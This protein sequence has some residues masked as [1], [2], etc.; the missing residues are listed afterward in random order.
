MASITVSSDP[1]SKGE[2]ATPSDERQS[3]LQ[4]LERFARAGDQRAFEQLVR[5]HEQL[6]LGVC[7]RQLR[8]QQDAEDAF[9][10]TFLVLAAKAGNLGWRASIS[11]WL[12]G[13]ALRV[14]RKAHQRRRRR[15][16]R[17]V[18]DMELLADNTLQRVA[19]QH[20]AEI[21][22]EELSRLPAKYR[23]PLV[24]FYLQGKSR[25]EAADELGLTESVVKGR[26]ERG[27]NRL[28]TRLMIRGVSLSLALAAVAA[29]QSSAAAAMVPGG[30][31]LG[32]GSLVATTVAAAAS[33]S[34]AQTGVSVSS[35][36]LSLVNG[37]FMMT[38][39]MILR[40]A[41]VTVSLALLAVC[42]LLPGEGAASSLS[43]AP[44]PIVLPQ[45]VGSGEARSTGSEVFFTATGETPTEKEVLGRLAGTWE[46]ESAMDGGRV[47]KLDE[48]DEV[49]FN[50]QG[51]RLFF[52]DNKKL[53]QSQI[54]LNPAATPMAID[55]TDENRRVEMPGIF[56]W[57]ENGKLRICFNESPKMTPGRPTKFASEAGEP[58]DILVTLRRI[59]T[60]SLRQ[61][62]QRM[63]GLWKVTRA[64]R[65]GMDHTGEH[66][67]VLIANDH[68]VFIAADGDVELLS[69][70]VAPR[71][72]PKRIDVKEDGVPVPGIYELKDGK[73]RICLNDKS[74]EFQRP[75]KFA[76]EADTP[77][78][79]LL[80]LERVPNDD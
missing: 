24:L 57:T 36:V 43:A 48:K 11:N 35:S 65:A 66:S 13:V 21:L 60:T 72:T 74:A 41:L 18:A 53:K 38:T 32:G 6:V 45:Q 67:E 47:V 78:V 64:A 80:E 46:V 69:F 58:H 37:E 17:E 42:M 9:Q 33:F 54:S 22:D 70:T 15:K 50:F 73:L 8:H 20:G 12:Y 14:A 2:V 71:A 1:V 55:I 4:L 27:R 26:L 30:S 56:E 7:R 76:S 23:A 51:K 77:N 10:A 49:S 75:T 40:C 5:R 29:S 68:L 19:D 61:D 31:V 79:R 3:D 52:L 44:Q 39:A 63:Q 34:P 59:E 25:R 16:E 62:A 28:R